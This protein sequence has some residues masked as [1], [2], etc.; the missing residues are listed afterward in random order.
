MI[1]QS[2]CLVSQIKQDEVLPRQAIINPVP[3]T[4][5]CRISPGHLELPN[6]IPGSQIILRA[7]GCMV[8]LPDEVRQRCLAVIAGARA[9]NFVM[10]YYYRLFFI[11]RFIFLEID[12]I[13]KRIL[14]HL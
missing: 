4:A 3:A 5:D 13:N 9:T 11:C 12:A 10:L 6:I 2:D 7:V 8:Q 14:K 1:K